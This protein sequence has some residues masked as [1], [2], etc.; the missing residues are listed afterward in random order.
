MKPIVR[1]SLAS[2]LLALLFNSYYD[3]RT[4]YFSAKS[5][6]WRLQDIEYSTLYLQND[7]TAFVQFF[8]LT[9]LLLT[10]ILVF[11]NKLNIARIFSFITVGLWI[12][13]KIYNALSLY[14]DYPSAMIRNLGGRLFGVIYYGNSWHTYYSINPFGLLR[15]ISTLPTTI[16]IIL[17]TVTL[18]I[19]AKRNKRTN[20]L[21]AEAPV[22]SNYF[23]TTAP[24]YEQPSTT[25]VCPECAEEIQVKAIK[26]RYCGYRYE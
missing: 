17:G 16:A 26:C 19:A 10:I 25:K 22:T 7:I 24:V 14:L 20:Y 9:F 8:V 23:V 6:S 11:V 2:L 5:L 4:F 15:N 1:V 3:G 18:F 12:S 21:H 13:I